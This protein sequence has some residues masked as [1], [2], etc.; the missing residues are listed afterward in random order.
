M[1]T[2][3]L[4]QKIRQFLDTPE[5]QRDYGVASEILLKITGN[6]VRHNMIMRRGPENFAA[7]LSKQL[8]DHYNFRMAKI[9]R[10]QVREMAN[11]AESVVKDI[12]KNNEE[13]RAGKRPDHDSLPD[14]VKAAYIEALDCLRKQRE[15]HMQIRNLA[16]GSSHCPDSELYPFV[17]EIIRLDDRRLACWRKY[18]SASTASN[19]AQ[20]ASDN[21]TQNPEN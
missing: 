4:T 11:K 8:S 19:P 10:Q 12:P 2:E 7:L 13:I 5:D 17:K 21:R 18:D 16:L 14:D 20:P 1:I 6:V 9:T 3:Q 15:L